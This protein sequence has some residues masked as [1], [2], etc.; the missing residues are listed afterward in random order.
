[1]VCIPVRLPTNNNLCVYDHWMRQLWEIR[2]T[3]FTVEEND[4]LSLLIEDER[5]KFLS[6]LS[7]NLRD[8]LASNF[9][10]KPRPIVLQ[11]RVKEGEYILSVLLEV[12]HSSKIA[13]YLHSPTNI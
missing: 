2:T 13:H 4:E 3:D 8:F 6:Q 9:A 7:S 1:M 11:K 10:S 5:K 12:G